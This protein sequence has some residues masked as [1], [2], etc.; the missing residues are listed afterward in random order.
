[1]RRAENR[2]V[3]IGKL[4]QSRKH[5][6]Q[7]WT[8]VYSNCST[9][10]IKD[11]LTAALPEGTRAQP[12]GNTKNK[13]SGMINDRSNDIIISGSNIDLTEALKQI[14]LEKTSKLFEHENQ[15]IRIRVELSLS[16]PNHAKAF[17]AKG[18]VEIKGKDLI[19]NVSSEDLYKSIDLLEQKL[20]RM[21]RRRSRLRVLKRKQPHSVDIPAVLPKVQHA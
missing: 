6:L 2:R 21:L 1:M 15:I 17:V 12:N 8:V 19:A 20:D 3:P 14:V 11:F 18:H 10:L 4:L 13:E 5:L 9:S 7:L 16:Q